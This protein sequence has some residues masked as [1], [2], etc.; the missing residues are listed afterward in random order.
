MAKADFLNLVERLSS[1]IAHSHT[2]PVGSAESVDFRVIMAITKR[3][4]AGGLLTS[5]GF[6]ESP[7]QIS[8]Q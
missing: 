6:K 2:R 7:I 1:T 4:L 8:T 5:G 3:F